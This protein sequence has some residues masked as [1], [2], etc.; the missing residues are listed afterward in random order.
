MRTGFPRVYFQEPK[1]R[2]REREA[3]GE[4]ALGPSVP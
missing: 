1:D 2:P 4:V 3:L